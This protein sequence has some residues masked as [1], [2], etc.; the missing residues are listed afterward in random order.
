MNREAATVAAATEVPSAAS[1][2]AHRRRTGSLSPADDRRRGAMD[3][4]AAADRR[5]RA[6]PR[7]VS[8]G[9][10]RASTTSSCIVLNSMI[11]SSEIGPDGE[12]RFNRA[13]RRPALRRSLFRA[14]IS[15]SRTAGTIA[16]RAPTPFPS[17]SL[18]DR[19]LRVSTDRHRRQAAPLRQ[20]RI[21]HRRPCR[22][23]ADRRAGRHP[24]RIDGALAL[25]GRPIARG[26]RRADPAAFARPCSGASP[27]SE[28]AC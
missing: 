14:S 25:P 19:R 10:R 17:R 2:R 18:W 5:L 9:R 3:R 26:A 27:R 28:S 11:G 6:R 16:G 20:Q 23:A 13:A 22:A 24:S 15:R 7:A 21:L 4:R 1:R 8:L 12:V